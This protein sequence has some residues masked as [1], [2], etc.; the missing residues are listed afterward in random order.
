MHLAYL[1]N[2]ICQISSSITQISI[3]CCWN[4]RYVF[5]DIKR[6]VH[7]LQGGLIAQTAT[8]WHHRLNEKKIGFSLVPILI[9]YQI[10]NPA[11][12]HGRLAYLNMSLWYPIPSHLYL[13]I[14]N[15]LSHP[16]NHRNPTSTS[17][18]NASKAFGSEDFAK[19][20]L[21]FLWFCAEEYF[22]FN[23]FCT[24]I[25]WYHGKST[26]GCRQI[27]QFRLTGTTLFLVN[28]S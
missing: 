3:R 25:R 18:R 2:S 9:P 28:F 4:I 19:M 12:S 14:L 17:I 15:F 24:S 7:D 22:S 13:R 16:C 21:I 11:R 5:W 10:Q 27:W 8:C 6:G 26:S 1:F 20:L 23:F